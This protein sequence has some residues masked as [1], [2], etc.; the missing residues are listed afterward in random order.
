MSRDLEGLRRDY[1]IGQL[2]EDDA[3]SDPIALFARWLG[4]AKNTTQLEPNAMTLATVDSVGTPHAR[5]VLLKGQDGRN[6]N[7]YTNYLSNKS[8]EL[9]AC[10]LAAL[11]FWWDQLER[12]VRVEGVVEKLSDKENDAYFQERPRGSRLGAW[13]SRQS[14]IIESHDVLTKKMSQLEDQYPTEIPRPSHW[15]GYR[16]RATRI[17]FWQGRS[18]RLHDRLDYRFDGMSWIRSRRS[19]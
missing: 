11:V 6:F 4:D 16:V 15:G 5:I 12:Q 17:E 7:F 18:S 8:E 10:P 2:H 9:T 13:A 1:Q 14:E 3:E 19:P